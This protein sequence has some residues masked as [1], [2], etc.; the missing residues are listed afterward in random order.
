MTLT[1]LP[2]E[3]IRVYVTGGLPEWLTGVV[4]PIVAAVIAALIV[5]AGFA[6]EARRGERTRR[7][8]FVDELSRLLIF[9]ASSRQEHGGSPSAIASDGMSANLYRVRAVAQMKPKEFAVY[10]YVSRQARDVLDGTEPAPQAATAL[11]ITN[12]LKWLTNERKTRDFPDP[13]PAETVSFDQ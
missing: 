10:D 2:P 5:V 4:V 12:L 1:E 6:I 8:A 11:A 7:V 9:S 3:P 13:P